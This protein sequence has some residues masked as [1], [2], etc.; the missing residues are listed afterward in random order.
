M[1]HSRETAAS[2]IV[3]T[4]C[5]LVLSIL[6][7]CGGGGGSG[8]AT[9]GGT[10]VTGSVGDG[11]IVGA[12][13]IITDASGKEI[14]RTVSDSSAKYSVDIPSNVQLPLTVSFQG[15]TDLV[16]G[17][18]PTVPVTTMV[19]DSLGSARTV[20][21]N[22][23]PF[24]KLIVDAAKED[25]ALRGVAVDATVLNRARDRIVS[26]YNFGLDPNVDPIR[27]T[28]T[29][30]N[31]AGIIK[32]SEALAE[33]IRRSANGLNKA[34][35]RSQ[36]NN[37]LKVA[38]KAQAV[39][40]VMSVL[41]ADVADGVVDGRIPKAK[42]KSKKSTTG[43]GAIVAGALT[44]GGAAPATPAASGSNINS[45]DAQ[46]IFMQMQANTVSVMAET[47]G[48]GLKIT[49]PIS[50]TTE[51]D[52]NNQPITNATSKLDSAVKTSTNNQF[53]GSVA[54]VQPSASAVNKIKAQIKIAVTTSKT[55]VQGNG[56]SATTLQELDAIAQDITAVASGS[57]TSNALNA[58]LNTIQNTVN[59]AQKA[60]E[61][62]AALTIAKNGNGQQGGNTPNLSLIAPNTSNPSSLIQASSQASVVA[63]TLSKSS[64]P[65]ANDVPTTQ[66]ATVGNDTTPPAITPPTDVYVEATGTLT[67]VL[68]GTPT[69]TDNSGAT[70]VATPDATGFFPLGTTV[71]TWTATDPSGNTATATQSVVVQDTT[72]PVINGGTALPSLTLEAT[73][74]TTPYTLVQPTATDNYAVAS[75]TNNAPA[76]F[77]LGTTVVTWTATDPS[78]NTATATQSVVVQDTTAPLI[79][80]PTNLVINAP[81]APFLTRNYSQIDTWISNVGAV[82][83]VD[84]SVTVGNNAPTA[85]LPG[86][87]TV[88]FTSSD[89]AGN[90]AAV[91]GTVT[92]TNP[93]STDA[94]YAFVTTLSGGGTGG[95]S[96]NGNASDSRFNN[97]QG[98]AYD[99]QGNLF[100]AEYGANK[101]RKITPD[102]TS[103]TFATIP[104]GPSDIAIDSLDNLYVTEY[105]GHTIKKITPTAPTPTVSVFAG[106]GIA[107]Y[108]DGIGTAAKF[109]RPYGIVLDRYGNLYV[110]EYAGGN[111]RKITPTGVVTT[112]TTG[113]TTPVGIDFLSNGRLVYT[114][115]SNLYTA[116][117]DGTGAAL[118]KAGTG[119]GFIAVNTADE[120][121]VPDS[122]THLIHKVSA[123]GSSA[124]SMTTVAGSGGTDSMNGPGSQASF[125]KPIAAVVDSHGNLTVTT[126]GGNQVRQITFRHTVDAGVQLMGQALSFDGATQFAEVPVPPA[127][128]QPTTAITVEAWVNMSTTGSYGI[129][130]TWDDATGNNRTY[131]LATSNGKPGFYVSSNGTNTPS[132]IATAAIATSS[133][134]HL[135]GTFDGS[136]IKVYVD[137]T[138][139]T[140]TAFTGTIATNTHALGIGRTDSF[141]VTNYWPGSIDEIK[142]WNTARTL[143]EV[144]YDMYARPDGTEAGLV[145]YWS[146]DE[147][148][149]QFGGTASTTAVDLTV[150]ANDATLGNGTSNNASAPI[151]IASTIAQS[152]APSI[153]INMRA[154]SSTTI[155]LVADNSGS[156]TTPSV[157]NIVGTIE[158]FVSP[159]AQIT[160]LGTVTDSN[161]RIKFTDS[162]AGGDGFDFNTSAGGISA[163]VHTISI[164]AL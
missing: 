147:P 126:T 21:A 72:K 37:I 103:S 11:P 44:V 71:V 99:S 102:G 55:L 92:V 96:V 83:T 48:N 2:P 66:S 23:N 30:G 18:S 109:N 58:K 123:T 41:A 148:G 138:L 94:A 157:S 118:L 65:F 136:N 95:T 38:S 49:N 163:P 15:G 36:I 143:T 124:G 67:A 64:M 29:P 9:T 131:L 104:G 79:T 151:S 164:N 135:S 153:T 139:Q 91:S 161:G 152:F 56:G 78:G 7:A 110:T 97:I 133:W 69:V 22:G 85:F 121:F 82:D 32:A 146:F 105:N 77:P 60:A 120:V 59:T 1:C 6:S 19:V 115:G 134:H 86:V 101:I 132:A 159:Y 16:T 116:K 54:N 14:A 119:S 34:R 61:T 63:A 12:T 57:K 43:K 76:S 24:S 160:P 141:G 88:T 137:G 73:G 93:L 142:I 108:A 145:G 98:M 107:G 111:I 26:A 113:L 39:Q 33:A 42:K 25:A 47:L 158:Q 50:G 52:A 140:K 17:K 46:S 27:T 8:S 31:A 81:P 84:G 45:A 130:G 122:T 144:Q 154:G 89:A 150:N 128:L 74:I 90:V 75:I 20:T 13:V 68:L 51:T 80:P 156:A 70:I 3:Y 100:V 87:T 4:A 10:T 117:P 35:T 40:D 162:G 106:S 149:N 112:V 127:S 53:T 28:M 125:N 155:P 129:V 114:S 5:A 62:A